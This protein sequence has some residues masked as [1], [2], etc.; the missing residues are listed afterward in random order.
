[1]IIYYSKKNKASFLISDTEL[2]SISHSDS[3]DSLASTATVTT[4]SPNVL[5][6]VSSNA[7]YEDQ[8]HFQAIF[9]NDSRFFD[10]SLYL[11]KSYSKLGYIQSN[12]E[13]VRKR[14]FPILKTSSHG[15]RHRWKQRLIGLGHSRDSHPVLSTAPLLRKN[16][17]SLFF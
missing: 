4:I 12:M 6:P 1:M 10:T 5:A 16:G 13:K 7:L 14:R 9:S 17:N 15:Y 8:E 2:M 11:Y 3:I